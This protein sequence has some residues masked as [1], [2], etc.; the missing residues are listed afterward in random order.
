MSLY[1]TR[2]AAANWQ[3][4]VRKTMCRMGFS[5]G[6]G[7]PCTYFHPGRRLKALVHEDDFVVAGKRS[8]LK[9]MS[10]RLKERFEVKC[11]MVSQNGEDLQ[12]ARI[13]NRIV[14]AVADG[15]EYMRAINGMRI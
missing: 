8:Q 15:W 7:N 10:Q 4:E 12:E 6:I 1:G 2:D 14:R 5:Q 9:W 11:Q 13:L 3:E